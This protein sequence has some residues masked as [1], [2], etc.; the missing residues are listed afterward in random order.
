[1]KPTGCFLGFVTPSLWGLE[2]WVDPQR[3]EQAGLH[4]LGWVLWPDKLKDQKVLH[5]CVTN[6][7]GSAQHCTLTDAG[8]HGSWEEA[9]FRIQI[10]TENVPK[11]RENVLKQEQNLTSQYEICYIFCSYHGGILK[12]MVLKYP[13]TLKDLRFPKYKAKVLKELSGVRETHTQN[14]LLIQWNFNQMVCWALLLLLLTHE[15]HLR[16]GKSHT[17]CPAN[18]LLCLPRQDSMLRSPLAAHVSCFDTS[19][20]PRSMVLGARKHTELS[21]FTPNDQHFTLW[22]TLVL[23]RTVLIQSLFSSF[24]LRLFLIQWTYSLHLWSEYNMLKL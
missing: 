7:E 18:I 6:D 5:A 16:R 14:W 22:F 4:A 20:D 15:T 24:L 11:I 3:T 12:L 21:K 23:N 19:A 13:Y 17:D 8:N 2:L 9:S 10:Q 1:M